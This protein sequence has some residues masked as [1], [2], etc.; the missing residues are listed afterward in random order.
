MAG[1][2]LLLDECFEAVRKV[3]YLNKCVEEDRYRLISES[4]TVQNSEYIIDT[5]ANDFN[6]RSMSVSQSVYLQFTQLNNAW[7]ELKNTP[8]KQQTNT[9][10]HTAMTALPL[11]IVYH[12]YITVLNALCVQ[13]FTYKSYLSSRLCRFIQ[14]VN[15]SIMLCDVATA[16]ELDMLLVQTLAKVRHGIDVVLYQLNEFNYNVCL[17]LQGT[18]DGYSVNSAVAQSMH[19]LFESI[20]SAHEMLTTVSTVVIKLLGSEEYGQF[21]LRHASL[22]NNVEYASTQYIDTWRQSS[23]SSEPV[24]LTISH[25]HQCCCVIT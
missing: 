4:S 10:Q 16:T 23:S 25:S 8:L 18:G 5:N 15:P 17:C 13:I 22:I 3:N 1:H 6:S 12:Q 19:N 9:T 21:K 24:V 14:I 20:Q 2:L 11:H 7:M